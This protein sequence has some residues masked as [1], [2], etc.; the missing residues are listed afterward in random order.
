M[1]TWEAIEGR[2]SIRKFADRPVQREAVEQILRAGIAA[3]SA[4]NR[5]PWRFVVATQQGEREGMLEAMRG[6]LEWME[7][8]G[9]QTEQD[10][11]F[12]KGAWYTYQ[13]MR[14][15]PVTVLVFNAEGKTP[16]EPLAAFGERFME[17]ANVQSVGACIQNMCLAATEMGLGSL[18]ICDVF[19]AY[20]TLIEWAGTDAQLA[21]AVSIGYA[22]EAPAARPRAALEEVTRWR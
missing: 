14:Q 22:D 13:I 6:G 15:A 19:E 10:R 21:A 7:E 3:P 16:F 9:V 17:L 8:H 4:K 12:L 2:R 11:Q 20:P 18:W 5:Q 1:N